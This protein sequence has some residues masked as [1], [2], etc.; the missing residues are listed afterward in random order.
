ML[1]VRAKHREV[2]SVVHVT[3]AVE[4]IERGQDGDR[5]RVVGQRRL[6][7]GGNLSIAGKSGREIAVNVRVI[8]A[9]ASASP[10]AAAATS[11]CS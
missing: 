3:E 10:A 2:L 11:T 7:G 5:R 4:P 8:R 1:E 6:V 9:A